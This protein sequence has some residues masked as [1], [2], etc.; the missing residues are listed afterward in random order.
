MTGYQTS[1]VSCPSLNLYCWSIDCERSSQ[2]IWLKYVA[3]IEF[4]YFVYNS[5]IYLWIYKILLIWLWFW[6][7][8]Y[9]FMFTFLFVSCLFVYLAI[10]LLLCKV[11][12]CQLSFYL[13]FIPFLYYFWVTISSMVT[14]CVIF[15]FFLTQ[16]LPI[17]IQQ[18]TR[19]R[20]SFIYLW[21]RISGPKPGQ[22][23]TRS[24]PD[25]IYIK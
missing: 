16:V 13:I 9:V 10:A 7:I 1:L 6:H 23:P 20:K 21:C 14:M 17:M 3:C 2:T 11:C 22:D 15:F 12:P 25:Q 19:I 5:I 18:N 4:F 8:F 24:D